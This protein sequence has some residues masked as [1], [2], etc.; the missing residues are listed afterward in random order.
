[1]GIDADVLAQ[2]A[3]PEAATFYRKHTIPKRSGRRKGEVREVFEPASEE[4]R[5]IH[6]TLNRR[7]TVYARHRDSTYP[8]PCC[9]GFVRGRSTLDNAERHLGQTLLL[10]IDIEN[11]F[12]SISLGRVQQLLATLDIQPACREILSRVICFTGFLVPGLSAS[13]LLA[14]LVSRGLDKRLT[15]LADACG[16][17]YTRY[18]DDISFSGD[19]VPT[20]VEVATALEAEGF[21]ISP[22]KQRLT[23]RG[24]A[25]FV[26]GLSI[27][28]VQRPHVPKLMKRRLR[29]EIYY[30]DKYGIDEH[31]LRINDGLSEGLHRLDGSVRYISYVERNTAFDFSDKWDSLLACDDRQPHIPTNYT[32]A[33]EPCFVAVD[34]AIIERAEGAYLVLGFAV[35]TDKSAIETRLAKILDDYLAS[36]FVTGKKSE[37]K[38][39]GLHWTDATASLREKVVN[40]LPTLPMRMLV[41]ICKLA[42]QSKADVEAA[43]LRALGWGIA[44]VLRRADR[45][46]LTL[47]IE[48]CSN[49]EQSKV[50]EAIARAYAVREK[51]GT[52]RPVAAP[53]VELVGKGVLSVTVPDFMLGVLGLYVREADG[54]EKG[55][56]AM[57]QFEQVRDRFSVIHD[58]DN[59]KYFSRRRRPFERKFF[60][61]PVLDPAFTN[62]EPHSS[63]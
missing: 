45:K 15:A 51:M 26:T 25:H 22:R 35:L 21:R 48:R 17:R 31:L 24:Q 30:C 55:Q 14:N 43:Y 6:K 16:A 28:D 18:A 11:Y 23:K 54:S 59:R 41:G 56:S 52:A 4:L 58:L 46:E 57:L 38:K 13:P 33:T 32:L 42:S 50:R 8:L 39:N 5:Q 10:R 44:D 62:S 49:V 1:M 60:G 27:H 3:S 63:E 36:P 7:L 9:F 29:Q 37:I 2:L 20:I 40:Q 53:S 61:A 12:P 47:Y 19:S 34:E